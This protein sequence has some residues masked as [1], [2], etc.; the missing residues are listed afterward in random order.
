[1]SPE[2]F[3]SHSFQ[4]PSYHRHSLIPQGVAGATSQYFKNHFI[5]INDVLL[6]SQH[7]RMC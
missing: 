4:C 1:M 6:F 5:D 3:V 2:G 7:L